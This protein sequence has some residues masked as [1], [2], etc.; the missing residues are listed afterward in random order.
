MSN[1]LQ[2]IYEDSWQAV[3]T[4]FNSGMSSSS[5]AFN[6]RNSTSSITNGTK[7]VK[8]IDFGSQVESQ[9][10]MLFIALMPGADRNVGIR[11]QLHPIDK[12][13]LPSNVKLVLLSELGEI[14][15]EVQGNVEDNY[16]QLK[17]FEGEVGEYFNIQVILNSYEAIEKFVI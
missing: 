8:V 4:F 9:E 6:L 7:R 2:G 5:L 16:V 15:Q 10:L 13:Y 12:E 17:L 3:E 14:I 11:V 1:W